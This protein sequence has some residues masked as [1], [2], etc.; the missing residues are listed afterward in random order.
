MC[1]LDMFA[2]DMYCLG[3]IVHYITHTSAQREDWEKTNV[4][5][6]HMTAPGGLFAKLKR[7]ERPQLHLGNSLPE[8]ILTDV[9]TTCWHDA[10]AYW[11]SA[12][13]IRHMLGRYTSSLVQS[14]QSN[15]RFNPNKRQGLN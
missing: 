3:M 2:I 7:G 5:M 6:H 8:R 12:A 1:E 14:V 15:L 4:Q 13:S 11:P 10:V 9:I